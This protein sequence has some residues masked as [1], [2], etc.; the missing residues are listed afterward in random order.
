MKAQKIRVHDR[1]KQTLVRKLDVS[2]AVAESLIKAN[3]R[4]VKVARK[5]SEQELRVV[6][7]VGVSIARR[8]RR[9]E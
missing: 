6:P 3:I 7:G 8:I 5:L 4:T 2:E 1:L 9:E